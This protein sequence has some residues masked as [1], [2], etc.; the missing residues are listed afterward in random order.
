MFVTPQML[1]KCLFALDVN[2]LTPSVEFLGLPCGTRADLYNSPL[3]HCDIASCL[4]VGEKS[5]T[6]Q[7]H[8]EFKNAIKANESI[9]IMCGVRYSGKTTMFVSECILPQLACASS[10]FTAGPKRSHRR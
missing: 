1:S 2:S 7:M 9:S 8:K 10:L 4:T 5:E 6:K 3:I